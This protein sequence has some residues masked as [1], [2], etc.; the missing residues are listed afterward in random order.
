MRSKETPSGLPAKQNRLERSPGL[1]AIALALALIGGQAKNAIAAPN[2]SNAPQASTETPNNDPD[3]FSGEMVPVRP[4]LQQSYRE[5]LTLIRQLL[6]TR[7]E[8]GDLVGYISLFEDLALS[9][10]I[11][12]TETFTE[13]GMHI[14]MRLTNNGS[15]GEYGFTIVMLD[16]EHEQS[17]QTSLNINVTIRGESIAIRTHYDPATGEMH[18]FGPAPFMDD[19]TY[20]LFN[21]VELVSDGST[22]MIKEINDTDGFEII[23]S[24]GNR[25][26]AVRANV[27][28]G[29]NNTGMLNRPTNLDLDELRAFDN[30]PLLLDLLITLADALRDENNP[31]G[32]EWI[33]NDDIPGL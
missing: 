22:P 31:L 25:S 14:T 18:T 12:A 23:V 29:G 3:L 17:A 32:Y 21:E 16:S 6:V 19:A 20:R 10:N 7:H 15:N 26:R 30:Q 1:T 33:E 27:N 9:P 8:N 13:N 24:T 4:D 2:D 5:V 28:G 11:Y